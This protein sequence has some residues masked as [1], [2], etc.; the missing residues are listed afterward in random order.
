LV[1]TRRREPWF[2][3]HPRLAL[4]VA[5]LLF[6][7]IFGLR[8]VV[9]GTADSLSVLYVLPVS[10][11]AF[12]FGRRAGLIAGAVGVGLLIVWV[13]ESGE[14]LSPLG[15][16]S[17]VTPMVLLG[18]LVGASSDRIREARRAE[19]YA[20]AVALVQRDAAEIND[21]VVQGL[22]AAKWLLESEQVERA[23]E[24]LDDTA[25]KAQT[26]VSRVLGADGVLPDDLRNPMMVMQSSDLQR[27][28]PSN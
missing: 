25:E 7:A 6:V 3:L 26:L 12:A 10:L 15:W 21:S 22:A 27:G 17:R 4:G 14:A 16:L 9:D 8:L 5:M 1:D 23:I 28:R 19:R 13:V 24:V 18:L 11:I 20:L 2:D